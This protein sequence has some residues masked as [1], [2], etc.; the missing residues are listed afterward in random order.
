[1]SDKLS[2]REKTARLQRLL[3]Q[4]HIGSNGANGEAWAYFTEVRNQTGFSRSTIRSADAIAMSLWPSRG[5]TLHGF[6]IK[7]SRADWLRELREPG[8]SEDFIRHCDH[9]WLVTEPDVVEDGELP[10]T[11]GLLVRRGSKLVQATA[12]PELEPEPCSPQFLA[13][14]LRAAG[15]KAEVR[16]EAITVAEAAGRKHG[17][18]VFKDR[19]E[20]YEGELK[21]LREKVRAFTRESGLTLEGRYPATYDPAELGRAVRLVLEGKARA[22]NLETRFSR[23]AEQAESIAEQAAKFATPTQ[24]QPPEQP[25]ED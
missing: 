22:E 24:Q 8:K 23:L 17:E 18:A 1:M 19:A 14:L 11:W 7:A 10:K 4:R 12:A 15:R 3:R 20:L 5:L 9:W 13:G 2:D 21:A 6:E 16:P 25:E